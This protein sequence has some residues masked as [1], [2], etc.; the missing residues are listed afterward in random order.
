MNRNEKTEMRIQ[1]PHQLALRF[2]S[3]KVF[4]GAMKVSTRRAPSESGAASGVGAGTAA[5]GTGAA[6]MNAS[7]EIR[8]MKFAERDSMNEGRWHSSR[9]AGTETRA[10]S[11]R[12]AGQFGW[13]STAV[14]T[15]IP[16]SA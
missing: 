1:G 16:L 5:G 15:E 6:A 11:R 13:R 14:E 7:C 9:P 3:V 4:E 8:W 10:A 2:R 12:L